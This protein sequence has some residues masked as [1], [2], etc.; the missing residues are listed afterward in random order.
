[1]EVP[2]NVYRQAPQCTAKGLMKNAYSG[3]THDHILG[4]T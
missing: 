1:M 3:A 4:N 2:L